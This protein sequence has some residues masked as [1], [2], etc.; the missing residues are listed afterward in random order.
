MF[1]NWAH[2]KGNKNTNSWQKTCNINI[3]EY[4]IVQIRLQKKIEIGNIQKIPNFADAIL[5]ILVGNDSLS[6]M[7]LPVTLY[8]DS[9][10]IIMLCL[11]VQKT[12]N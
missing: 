4:F 8:T 9:W 6:P 11:V 3:L 1:L 2:I 7:G 12:S 5:A 10:K